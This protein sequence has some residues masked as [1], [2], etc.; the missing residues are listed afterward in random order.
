MLPIVIGRGKCPVHNPV[1]NSNTYITLQRSSSA[2]TYIIANQ[3]LVTNLRFFGGA[4]WRC[5]QFDMHTIHHATISSNAWCIT[6]AWT[7]WISKTVECR[8]NNQRAFPCDTNRVHPSPGP[9]LLIALP[10]SQLFPHIS[11]CLIYHTP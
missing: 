7:K 1:K 11:K 3:Q 10:F 9:T 6:S 8:E 4:S 2:T 5:Q